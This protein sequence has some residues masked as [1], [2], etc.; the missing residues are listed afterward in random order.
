MSSSWPAKSR[1]NTEVVSDSCSTDRSPGMRVWVVTQLEPDVPGV[2]L[3][4]ATLHLTIVFMFLCA[5]YLA[6]K[7]P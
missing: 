3:V 4:L 6:L 5:T 7:I 1:T 2:L